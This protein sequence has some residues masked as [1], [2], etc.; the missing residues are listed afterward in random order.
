MAFTI[1]FIGFTLDVLGKLFIAW[2]TLRIHIKHFRKHRVKKEDLRLDV[3][4]SGIGIGMIA[5]GYI[6]RI[7]HELSL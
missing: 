1:S 7:P 5:L 2:V 4:L 3:W 6:L